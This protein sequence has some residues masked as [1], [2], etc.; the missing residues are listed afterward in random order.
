MFISDSWILLFY[1]SWI[2]GS[3]KAPVPG[4]VSSALLFRYRIVLWGLCKIE[5]VVFPITSC[6]SIW[7]AS[8][9]I[10]VT[11]YVGTHLSSWV[12]WKQLYEI[13]P[14]CLF[15]QT[16]FHFCIYFDQVT[17]LV[18]GK[19]KTMNSVRKIRSYEDE[20]DP[21]WVDGGL[22]LPFF[23]APRKKFFPTG[24]S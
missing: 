7:R 16:L 10:I 13:I 18:K 4:S 14:Y 24:F 21:K 9:S 20:F 8:G 1:P 6:P 22:S 3:K 2:Q 5:N 17:D 23:K 12:C 11:S 15:C 19:G